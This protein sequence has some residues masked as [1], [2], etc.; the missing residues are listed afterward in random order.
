MPPK[1]TGGEEKKT[2]PRK[3]SP[4]G[5]G[6]KGGEPK[7]PKKGLTSKF[8]SFGKLGGS[9]SDVSASPAKKQKDPEREAAFEELKAAL[10]ACRN[11][12]AANH[13]DGVDGLK[14]ANTACD[15][16][17][18][19]LDAF[20]PDMDKDNQPKP[21]PPAELKLMEASKEA[22][23]ACT[24]IMDAIAEKKAAAAKAIEDAKAAAAALAAD[25]RLVMGRVPLDI[26][27][28]V[29]RSAI[30]KAKKD[31]LPELDIDDAKE[32]L[33]RKEDFVK[34]LQDAS[35]DLAAAT[36]KGLVDPE[37]LIAAIGRAKERQGVVK[38]EEVRALRVRRGR[39]RKVGRGTRPA[40]EGDP[41]G[42][43]VSAVEGR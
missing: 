16:A 33:L 15:E 19:K 10:A 39:A 36:A 23:D 7:S 9:S 20:P 8:K 40:E 5:D 22:I 6:K 24:A 14:A 12:A 38:L 42:G 27:A 1:P 43:G 41:T 29:L 13:D 26:S 11:E 30:A 18:K 32:A 35:K 34:K 2:T 37:G 17:I 31:K 25:F 4:R 21:K 3:G 28:E